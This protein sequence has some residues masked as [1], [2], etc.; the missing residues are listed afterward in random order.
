MGGEV[1]K[2]GR[3]FKVFSNSLPTVFQKQQS[4]PCDKSGVA[5]EIKEAVVDG[6]YRNLWPL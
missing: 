6:S 3:E 1:Q 4:G 5:T 2:K